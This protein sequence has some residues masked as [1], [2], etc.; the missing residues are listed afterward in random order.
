[1]FLLNIIHFFEK[2][3]KF[4]KFRLIYSCIFNYLISLMKDFRKCH[5]LFKL[6]VN[7]I[8]IWWIKCYIGIIF[9]SDITFNFEELLSNFSTCL[10]MVASGTLLYIYNDCL[11]LDPSH[12]SNKRNAY[13]INHNIFLKPKW[14]NSA[15][16]WDTYLTHVVQLWQ[17]AVL[18]WWTLFAGT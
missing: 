17:E 16:H 4:M 14:Y 5:V 6:G 10:N 12:N 13:T 11:N 7:A 2:F 3:I 18:N 9:I 1:M 15:E 8:I